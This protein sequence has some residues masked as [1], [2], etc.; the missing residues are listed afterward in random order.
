MTQGRAK[1]RDL[2]GGGHHS[3]WFV[4]RFEAAVKFEI[5]GYELRRP[6]TDCCE[7][8]A[9]DLPRLPSAACLT[10]AEHIR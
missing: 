3:N 1:S 6:D 9:P 2:W 4:D 10:Q 5:E 7:K 8:G